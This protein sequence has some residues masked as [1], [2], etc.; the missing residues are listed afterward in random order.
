MF[1]AL[2]SAPEQNIHGHLKC[3][4]AV[5]FVQCAEYVK[6]EVCLLMALS[7][8]CRGCDMDRMKTVIAARDVRAPFLLFRNPRSE[9]T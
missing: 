9:K 5:L 2:L 4:F 1:S 8:E 3:A 7:A 6:L